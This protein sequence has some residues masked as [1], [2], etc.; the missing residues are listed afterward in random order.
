VVDLPVKQQLLEE[1]DALQRL[2]AERS[3]LADEMRM[4]RSLS[5]TAAPELRYTP[6]SQN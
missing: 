3:L 5:L 6:Y 4:M 1:P 2:A